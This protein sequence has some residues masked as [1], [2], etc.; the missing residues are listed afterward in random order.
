[1]SS[2]RPRAMSGSSSGSFQ[3]NMKKG[4]MASKSIPCRHWMLKVS[5]ALIQEKCCVNIIFLRATVTSRMTASLATATE[6]DTM[7]VSSRQSCAECSSRLAVVPMGSA[8]AL[9]TETRT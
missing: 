4:M 2:F 9:P 5:S 8:V 7:G 1:M 6:T 3:D